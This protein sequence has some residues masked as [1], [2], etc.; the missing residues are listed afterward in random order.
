MNLKYSLWTSPKTLYGAMRAIKVSRSASA[1]ARTS[2]S[3]LSMEA[4]LYQSVHEPTKG[5][6]KESP[7]SPLTKGSEFLVHP[8][9]DSGFEDFFLCWLGHAYCPPVDVV[10]EE[11]PGKYV[12]PLP[13]VFITPFKVQLYLGP[14]TVPEKAAPVVSICPVATA[15]AKPVETVKV[16]DGTAKVFKPVLLKN[17]I[18]PPA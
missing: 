14:E 3:F 2:C 18:K 13:K 11:L 17:E 8:L 15:L 5:Q 9:F 12:D 6:N 10:P 4:K 7:E 16:P 1:R